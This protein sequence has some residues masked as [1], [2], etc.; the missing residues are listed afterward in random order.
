MHVW[1]DYKHYIPIGHI[2][3]MCL[4]IQLNDFDTVIKTE[5]VVLLLV[6]LK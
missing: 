1:T 5:A 2:N 3:H 6:R 4:G